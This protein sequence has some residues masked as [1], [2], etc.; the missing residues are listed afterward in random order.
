MKAQEFLYATTTLLPLLCL[1]GCLSPQKLQPVAKDNQVN[2]THYVAASAQLQSEHRKA[3]VT[4]G[5]V[6]LTLRIR[7]LQKQIIINYSADSAAN[8]TNLLQQVADIQKSG[9]VLSEDRR[10]G[11]PLDK[12]IAGD[13]AV[14]LLTADRATAIIKCAFDLSTDRKQQKISPEEYLHQLALQLENFAYVRDLKQGNAEILKAYD[15]YCD[16]MQRQA[17]LAQ[18]HAEVILRF[19]N[20]KTDFGKTLLGTFS[21]AEFQGT[22][23][24]LIPNEKSKAQAK[25]A[26]EAITQLSATVTKTSD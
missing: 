2:I 21:D 25:L 19:S 15:A 11:L 16:I 23:L 7:T 8:M 5:E 14:G 24:D 12:P 20:A 4:Q 6:A 26:L 3:L 1:T 13:V 10:Q 17:R 9:P 22:I 18:N